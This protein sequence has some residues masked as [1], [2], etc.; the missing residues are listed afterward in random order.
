MNYFSR[1]VYF[2]CEAKTKENVAHNQ[3]ENQSI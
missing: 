2:F 1:N 3:E